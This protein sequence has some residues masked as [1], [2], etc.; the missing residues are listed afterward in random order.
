M[1][2]LKILQRRSGLFYVCLVLLGLTGA[3]WNNLLLVL[4]NSKVTASPLPY[5]NEFA[6]SLY[7]LLIIFSF[8]MSLIFQRYVLRL[9]TDLSFEMG[10]NILDKVRRAS[11]E[12]FLRFGPEKVYSLLSDTQTISEFPRTFI[13][14]FN[15]LVVFL[16]AFFYLFTISV[17]GAVLIFVSLVVLGWIYYYRTEKLQVF[18]DEARELSDIYN[19]NIVDLL[20]GFKEIKMSS[21]RSK[22]LFEQLNRN[23]VTAKSLSFKAGMKYTQNDLL[24]RYFWYVIIGVILFGLHGLL[25]LPAVLIAKFIVTLLFIVGPVGTLIGVIP[26]YARLRTALRKLNEFETENDLSEQIEYADGE[27]N[28]GQAGFFKRICVRDIKYLYPGPGD[29]FSLFI[30]DLEIKAGEIVFISGGNGSGKS[31]FVN[32]LAGLFIP[33]SGEIRFNDIVVDASNIQWYR[34]RFSTIFSDNYILSENYN[35]FEIARTNRDLVEYITFMKMN[36]VVTFEE[37]RNTLSS[38][39]SKGQQKRLSMIYS[40]LEKKDI[41]IL[42]EWAADQDPEFRAYFYLE[43]LPVLKQMKKTVIL[44][45]HDDLYYSVA[46]RIIKFDKGRIVLDKS[47]GATNE[48][49]GIE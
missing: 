46:E 35:N 20:N 25:M 40:L 4:I 24:G 23:R 47:P 29:N 14:G 10:I 26:F 5:F 17:S 18:I 8:L 2:I 12:K 21:V 7:C 45:T 49:A 32:I 6:F 42:D 1:S 36:E 3:V 15:A 31:T 9:S 33:T 13:D 11:F 16:V 30:G 22:N 38:K 28:E 48:K 41:V 27:F 19:R 43:F 44:I 37:K 39:L 34:D